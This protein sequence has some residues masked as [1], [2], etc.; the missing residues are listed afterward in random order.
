MQLV[1][2]RAAFCWTNCQ[3][4]FLFVLFS[5]FTL[6]SV[7]LP[8]RKSLKASTRV[9]TVRQEP[10][11][12]NWWPPLELF[13]FLLITPQL[14]HVD[15]IDSQV[16]KSRCTCCCCTLLQASFPFPAA[17]SVNNCPAAGDVHDHTTSRMFYF[18]IYI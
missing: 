13:F 15:L 17:V 11:G 3:V 8:R 9:R 1:V 4:T 14:L 7:C 5:L 6:R 10:R 18:V 2:L 16:G 12:T